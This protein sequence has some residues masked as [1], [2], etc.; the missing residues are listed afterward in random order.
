[1]SIVE[2][3]APIKKLALANTIWDTMYC[4]DVWAETLFVDYGWTLNKAFA[5]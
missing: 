2:S 5:S 3:L 1:M 4:S